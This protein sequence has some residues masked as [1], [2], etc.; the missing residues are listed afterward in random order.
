MLSVGFLLAVLLAVLN[1]PSSH[2]AVLIYGTRVVYSEGSRNK[3][4]RLS[5]EGDVPLLIQSWL[6][7]GEDKPVTEQR[8]PFVIVPPVFRMNAHQG[9]VM[10]INYTGEVLPK[11]K[12]SVFY[13]NVL[14]IPPKPTMTEQQNM[15]QLAVRNRIKLFFRPKALADGPKDLGAQLQWKM[16]GEGEHVS[17]TVKNPTP[18]FASFLDAYVSVNGT[19]YEL[20]TDM[21][22][23]GA[24]ATFPL[25]KPTRLPGR[26]QSVQFKLIDDIGAAISGA[27]SLNSDTSFPRAETRL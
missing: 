2:A 16:T 15:L 21:V 4:V 19:S 26:V 9:Q 22:G 1:V 24:S 13:L 18:F 12:E 27:A 14:E 20:A 23:P 8:V 7:T 3:L 5:N 11:D 25:L 17:L 6:D 10:R